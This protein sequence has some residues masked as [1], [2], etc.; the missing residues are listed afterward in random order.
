[1]DTFGDDKHKSL[2]LSL[3]LLAAPIGVVIGYS[4]TAIMIEN[5]TWH[6]IFYLQTVIMVPVIFAFMFTDN[7]YF[8]IDK[9]V[10]RKKQIIE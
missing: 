4:L 6:W 2:W 1:V 7:K 9:A 5:L 10:E 3:L 8:L